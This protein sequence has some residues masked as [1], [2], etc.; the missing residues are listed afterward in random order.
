MSYCD[1]LSAVGNENYFELFRCRDYQSIVDLTKYAKVTF[2]DDVVFLRFRPRDDEQRIMYL[3]VCEQSSL[4]WRRNEHHGVSNPQPHDCLLNHIF[5]RRS[6]KTSKL[7]LTGL[8]AGNSPGTGE[9]PAQ[10]ASNAENVSIFWRHHVM[11]VKYK[12]L[13]NIPGKI[14]VLYY[15]IITLSSWHHLI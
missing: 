5:R 12:V 9:F 13:S 3:Y 4:Q 1:I 11:T 8:C 2:Q 6:K 10:R 7:R 14:Y 15:V